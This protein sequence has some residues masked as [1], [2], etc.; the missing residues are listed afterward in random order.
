MFQTWAQELCVCFKRS[1]HRS[2]TWF[3]QMRACEVCVCFKRGTTW[4]VFVSKGVLTNLRLFSSNADLEFLCLVCYARDGL[5][6]EIKY[7]FDEA[8]LGVQT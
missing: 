8:A 6:V 1:P 7:N 3:V 5:R 2:Q 4:S